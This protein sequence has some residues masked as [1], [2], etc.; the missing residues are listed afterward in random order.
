MPK[1]KY[2]PIVLDE[3]IGF[4]T[5]LNGPT[6][7]KRDK[8]GRAPHWYCRCR[9]GTAR[10]ISAGNLKIMRADSIGRNYYLSC[11]CVRNALA[12]LAPKAVPY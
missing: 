7:L 4:W 9:C 11:G 6:S 5:V 1:A 2:P 8:G 3:V 10:F 12:R